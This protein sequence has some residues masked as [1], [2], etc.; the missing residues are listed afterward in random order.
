[1]S[2]IDQQSKVYH[3][4]DELD[5]NKLIIFFKRTQDI[6][7]PRLHWKW[8]ADEITWTRIAISELE[9]WKHFFF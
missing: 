7:T 4:L 5:L 6:F 3:H 9:R 8:I 1:M 2:C